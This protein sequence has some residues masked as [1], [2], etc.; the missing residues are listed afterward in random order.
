MG[1][2]HLVV[3]EA[4][5][6]LFSISDVPGVP[7]GLKPAIDTVLGGRDPDVDT[8]MDTLIGVGSE[9]PVF[10]VKLATETYKEGKKNVET[11]KESSPRAGRKKLWDIIHNSKEGT[12]DA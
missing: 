9:N 7:P 3:T 12:P 1:V 4:C 6:A 5:R 10:P 2:L 8:L 11:Y